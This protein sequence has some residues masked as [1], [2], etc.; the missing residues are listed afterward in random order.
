[1]NLNLRN[2]I[3]FF[4]FLLLTAFSGWQCSSIKTLSA[5]PSAI[6]EAPDYS[7]YSS[8]AALPQ[9]EDYADECPVPEMIDRQAKAS[10]DIFFIHPTTDFETDRW[11]TGLDDARIN[12]KTDSQPVKYQASIFN[13][14]GRIF[15]PRYRQM[16]YWGFFSEDTLAEEKAL[17]LAYSDVRRAFQYYLEYYN[18]G[19]PVVIATHS[20]GSV[21]GIWLLKEFFD[22]TDL[23]DQL[24][25]AYL[26][27]W[28]IQPGT[29]EHI[30]EGDSATQTG[31]FL[32]W[33]SFRKGAI[34]D[35]PAYYRGAIVTNPLNWRSDGSFAGAENHK[36]MVL[37][38]FDEVQSGLVGAQAHEGVL[39]V[40]P[41]RIFPFIFLKNMHIADYNLFYQDV[42]ANVEER[43]KAW[44]AR[45]GGQ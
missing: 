3:L 29:F 45:N 37:R 28:P 35:D 36:G 19:R 23:Q 8:W 25:A 31:C 18:D 15:A 21:H 1:M 7:R 43:V 39:W 11:N 9:T 44:E 27:G 41:E 34:P 20:Q 24:V 2:R 4:F 14:A 10:A 6:P 22:G 12:R 32:S 42:R 40:Y 33:C 5:D 26:V 30:P 38:K 16:S 13:G 17:Q